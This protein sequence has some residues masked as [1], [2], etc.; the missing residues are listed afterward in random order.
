MLELRRGPDL[1]HEPLGANHG[2]QL[3]VQHLQCDHAAVLYVLGEIDGGHAA[4]AEAAL[5]AVA[6]GE[7]R[8]ELVGDFS[9]G[10]QSTPRCGGRRVNVTRA[11]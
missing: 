3:G 7:V 2:S 9:H 5:D 8:G 10:S 6:I 1:L 4:F 11:S